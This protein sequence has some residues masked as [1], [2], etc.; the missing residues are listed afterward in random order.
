MNNY[1]NL[2]Q[3]LHQRICRIPPYFEQDKHVFC[4]SCLLLVAILYS[5][6]PLFQ[7]KQEF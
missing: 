5:L 7:T 6:I 1:C 4:L 2:A 3:T